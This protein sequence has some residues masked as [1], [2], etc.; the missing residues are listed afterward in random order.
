MVLMF[1][2]CV[3]SEYMPLEA[4]LLCRP[5][6]RIEGIACP[7]D[8]LH[9]GKIDYAGLAEEYEGIIKLYKTLKIKVY[10][11]DSRKIKGTD[12]SYIFN[13]M[14][15]RDLFFMISKGAILSRMCF[16]IRRDEVKYAQRALRRIRVFIRKSIQAGATFEGADALWVNDRLVVVG[17]GKRTNAEG[18]MQVKEELRS[19][20]VRCVSVPAPQG[21][22]HLLGALQFVDSN[23]ALVRADSINPQ[24]LDL[25]KR[26]KIKVI[27]I[28]EGPELIKKQAMNFV[29][30]APRTIIMPSGCPRTKKI[31]EKAGL[32]VAAEVKATGLAAGG[33]GLACATGILARGFPAKI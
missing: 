25:L 30:I 15:A 19:D 29:T 7:G 27:S 17:T 11:I 24:I 28:P 12:E 13:L 31:Y 32:K 4:V 23:L 3:N 5:E 33:G 26:N 16:D 10:F 1:R 2:Y 14:Y 6:R 8:V 20:G 9:V 18:F 22:L 21:S